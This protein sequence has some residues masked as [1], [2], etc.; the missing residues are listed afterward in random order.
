MFVFLFLLFSTPF[1]YP[2]LFF[3]Y[4]LILSSDSRTHTSDQWLPPLTMHA[5]QHHT[6]TPKYPNFECWGNVTQI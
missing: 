6:I 3:P 2:S 1:L 4:I 5:H